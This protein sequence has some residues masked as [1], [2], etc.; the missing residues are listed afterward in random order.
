MDL[1]LQNDEYRKSKCSASGHHLANLEH[2][3]LLLICVVQLSRTVSYVPYSDT[4]LSSGNSGGTYFRESRLLVSCPQCILLSIVG[5][6]VGRWCTL[7]TS[8]VSA[9]LLLHV[10]TI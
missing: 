4:E 1:I 8:A 3:N 10:Y 7:Q 6:R 2:P 9:R 5:T